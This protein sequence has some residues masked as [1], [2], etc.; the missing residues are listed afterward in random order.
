MKP[1]GIVTLT[2]DFG[3]ADSYV[4]Q[5]K[6][7]ALAVDPGL[8]LVDLCHEV[9]S[10]DVAAGAYLLESGYAAFPEGTIHVAV[11]DPGVGTER[12]PIAVRADRHFFVGPDNGLLSRVLRREASREA[13]VL[14][15][16]A[17]RRPVTSPTF[18]GRDVFAPA[19]AWIARG[20]DLERFGPAAG[21]LVRL[22][23]LGRRLRRGAA[24][25]LRV[26]WID[27]FGNVVLDA[28]LDSLTET[29]G[30]PPS[31]SHDLRL[32]TPRG[33]VIREFRRTYATGQGR[34]PFLLIN[35]ADY[36]EVA[37]LSDRADRRLD[38]AVGVEVELTLLG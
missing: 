5:M 16:P 2:T 35:S 22:P 36:L 13:H 24:E 21:D 19:A 18:E 4:G 38:L 37:V 23:G 11:V 17:L 14:R 10:H 15:D 20:V 27:R 26:V 7:A 32:V 33:D 9:P 1:S 3:L 25:R 12:R 30:R 6:G 31:S 8:R 34:G 29:L 28:R